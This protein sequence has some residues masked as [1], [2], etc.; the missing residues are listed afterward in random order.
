VHAAVVAAGEPSAQIDLL[1]VVKS[2]LGCVW[3]VVACARRVVALVWVREWLFR[4]AGVR[5]AMPVTLD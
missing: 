2:A 3:W 4:R 1:F 5:G